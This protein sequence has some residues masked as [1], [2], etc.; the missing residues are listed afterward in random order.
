M[1]SIQNPLLT[2][3]HGATMEQAN[4]D[5]AAQHDAFVRELAMRTSNRELQALR[6]QNPFVS[7]MPLSNSTL[8]G[9][10]TNA[11]AKDILLPEG[12]KL[13]YITASDEIYISRNGAAQIPSNDVAGNFQSANGIDPRNRFLYVE[14][15]RSISII[16]ANAGPIRVSI[17]CLQQL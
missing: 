12:T 7:I 3:P 8:S 10:V 4:G 5:Q 1:N 6:A 16:G 14:E 15:L 13:I 11:S 2:L 9:T 17:A